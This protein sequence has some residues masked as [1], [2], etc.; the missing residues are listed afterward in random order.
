[1]IHGSLG[2][3]NTAHGI[4]EHDFTTAIKDLAPALRG[5][6]NRLTRNASDSDDLVQEALARAWRYR[7]RFQ[8]GTNF[9]GWLF[10]ILRNCFLSAVRRGRRQVAWNPQVHERGLVGAADQELGLLF[11]DLERALSH[12]PPAFA[13]ALVLVTREDLT[14]DDAAARLDLPVGTIKSQVHRARIAVMRYLVDGSAT[15][16]EE[17]VG[18]VS[19]DGQGASGRGRYIQWKRTKGRTIG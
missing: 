5:Y 9:K 16:R 18:A 10:R 1:M 19:S 15:A 6:A 11:E 13:D 12:L 4:S 7:D 17:T 8:A 2:Y 14:Y 3:E